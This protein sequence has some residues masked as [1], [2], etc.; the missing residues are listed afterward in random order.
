MPDYLGIPREKIQVVP[1]GINL[2]GY[3]KAD[4]DAKRPFTVGYFARIAP[5]KG[6]HDLALAYKLLRERNYLTESR[7]EVAGYLG[8]E[9]ESYLVDIESKLT[10]WGLSQEYRYHGVLDREEKIKFLQGIDLLSVPATYKEPKGV[11]LLEAMACGVPVVQPAHG[12]FPEVVEKTGGGLLVE[13]NDPN[14]LAEGIFKLFQNPALTEQLGRNGL[15]GVHAHYSIGRS[16]DRLI[17]AY[18]SLNMIRMAGVLDRIEVS[19]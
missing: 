17:E 4:R 19:V 3:A 12:A 14:A 8:P 15:Q 13:P 2:D 7:L 11:F 6:L 5:E 16:T 9:H 18:E 10:E 1:L